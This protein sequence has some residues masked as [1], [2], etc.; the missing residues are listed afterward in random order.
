MVVS[1]DMMTEKATIFSSKF[2][3]PETD[4]AYSKVW[5]VCFKIR[6]N[7]ACFKFHCESASVD[8]K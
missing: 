8:M 2:H 1:D 4:F 7:I 6:R 3:I 5:F